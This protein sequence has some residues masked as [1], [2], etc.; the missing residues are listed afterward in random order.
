MREIQPLECKYFVVASHDK[1]TIINVENTCC[2]QK[3]N[4]SKQ[5][6][7]ERQR[8]KSSATQHA[9]PGTRTRSTAAKF[10]GVRTTT[11]MWSENLIEKNGTRGPPVHPLFRR[12]SSLEKT[13]RC[14]SASVSTNK[15]THV[16]AGNDHTLLR[17]TAHVMV[18][19]VVSGSSRTSWM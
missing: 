17:V 10:P 9:H 1:N 15:H 3:C 5:H 8:Q 7:N 12:S 14:D 18:G 4:S 16:R 19:A 6:T 13:S 11:Y 2:R